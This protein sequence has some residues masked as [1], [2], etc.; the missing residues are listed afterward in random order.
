MNESVVM[1]LGTGVFNNTE[2]FIENTE[3]I[4][5]RKIGLS[6]MFLTIPM[7]FVTILLNMSVLMILWKKEKTIVNQLMK[8][9]CIVNIMYS[10]LGT[11][12]L[13]PY[14]RGFGLE[15]YCF[16]HMA[17]SYGSVVFN[18]MLPVAIVVFR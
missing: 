2:I 15:V 16:L 4:N 5:I 6:F 3:T 13:S 10:S 9:D 17:L 18:R 1:P 14:Y 7:Y 8:L 11:F 12:G